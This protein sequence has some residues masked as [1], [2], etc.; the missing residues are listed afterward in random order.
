MGGWAA[1]G[2]GD[3]SV[4]QDYNS[5]KGLLHYSAQIGA[6]CLQGKPV[7]LWGQG[8]GP[9]RRRRSRQLVRALLPLA[10]AIS[11]R[12][13]AS[14]SLAA[15]W[16]ITAPF[17]SDPAWAPPTRPRPCLSFPSVLAHE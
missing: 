11:W 7:G 17:G 13:P 12:D 5:L 9:L 10:S 15:G 1:L 2:G 6:A 4:N 14:A 3:S 16:G 8:L